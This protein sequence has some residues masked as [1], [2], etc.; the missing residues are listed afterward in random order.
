VRADFDRIAGLPDGGWDHNRHYHRWLLARVPHACRSALEIG[1]GTGAFAR[2]LARRAGCV[3]A[4]DLSPEMIR[5]ARTREPRR[6]N[7]EYRIADVARVELG[8]ERFDCIASL[9][10]LHHLEPYAL[11]ARMRDALRPGGLLLVLDL[12]TDQGPID[13]LRSALAV[14]VSGALRLART[15]RL[16]DPKPVRE[17]WAEHGR[18][19]RYPTLREV[20]ALCRE[21]L[22]GAE[23]RRHLLWRYSIVW[24][25]PA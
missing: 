24:R 21:L 1:C 18:G 4:L 6:E 14:P 16:R 3:L 19:E 8:R 11:L 25:K 7:L 23:V 15:G 20:G 12:V 9:A 5:V 2:E 22:P 17:A 13:G 10:T